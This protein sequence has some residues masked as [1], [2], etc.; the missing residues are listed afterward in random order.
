MSEGSEQGELPKD[1]LTPEQARAELQ[2]KGFKPEDFNRLA[3]HGSHLIQALHFIAT[4][5]TGKSLSKVQRALQDA[6]R[7]HQEQLRRY[8]E[9]KKVNPHI[10]Q[11]IEK[12]PSY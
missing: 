4:S 10:P 8:A 11:K 2:R 9:Q 6:D 12:R 5:E 7:P 3:S 1:F